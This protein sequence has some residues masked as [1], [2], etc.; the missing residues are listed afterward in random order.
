VVVLD[1]TDQAGQLGYHDLTTTGKPLGKVFAATDHVYSHKW[2][3]TASHELLEMLVDP[4][5][6]TMV[7]WQPDAG[8]GLLCAYEICD[9]V[10]S[11]EDGYT[12]AGT[13]VSDFVYPAWFV[14]NGLQGRQMDHRRHV[15]EPFEVR[16]GGYI[17]AF[18]VAGGKGWHQIGSDWAWDK[19]GSGWDQKTLATLRPDQKYSNL[20]HGRQPADEPPTHGP[21]SA[22]RSEYAMRA[23]I[24]SRR[25]RRQI[26]RWV[27]SNLIHGRDGPNVPESATPPAPL[28]SPKVLESAP[29]RPSIPGWWWILATGLV[30][31]AGICSWLTARDSHY[32]VAHR[33]AAAWTSLL[34][35]VALGVL[36]HVLVLRYQ[37]GRANEQD[38]VKP[39]GDDPDQTLQFRRRGLKAAFIGADG[40][41]STSKTQI[42][43]WTT[44]VIAGLVDLLLLTR[45]VSGGTLFTDAVTK[46]WHPEYL[47]LLGLPA[48]A[49]TVAKSAVS[50]SNNGQGPVKAANAAR[51]ADAKFSAAASSPPPATAAIARRLRDAP[52]ALAL[53]TPPQRVYVRDPVKGGVW[54]LANGIAELLTS[55]NGQLAWADAQYAAFTLVALGSFS[56][57]LLGNPQNG[58]PLVPA[59]L[60][61][62]M[63]VSATTYTANKAVETRGTN[64]VSAQP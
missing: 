39:Q 16:P 4:W 41:A 34:V 13:R 51:L 35:I 52:D 38:P 42:V 22:L 45:S 31:A 62:L 18:D 27:Y 59:A 29:R 10:E 50:G 57:Q 44:A 54:G 61:T 40:R 21:W 30:V 53:V 48:A 26:P 2:T 43:L 11:D 3:V 8:T 17:G 12:I 5:I 64:V 47:V 14:D 49:A 24:G 63:G 19:T 28:P 32:T 33:Q 60:L 1:N 6:N 56:A 9:P 20:I 58:L 7:F 37:Y 55:D 25:E 15:T 36:A 23:P 46:N